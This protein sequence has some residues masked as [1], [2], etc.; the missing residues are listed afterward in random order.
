MS[1]FQTQCISEAGGVFP[2]MRDII[3]SFLFKEQQQLLIIMMM[4]LLLSFYKQ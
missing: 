1:Y 3:S 4:M 2:L